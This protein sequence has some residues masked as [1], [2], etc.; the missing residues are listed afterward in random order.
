[1]NTNETAGVGREQ[2]KKTKPYHTIP[3]RIRTVSLDIR[4]YLFMSR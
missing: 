1:M 3:Y 2:K 4:E